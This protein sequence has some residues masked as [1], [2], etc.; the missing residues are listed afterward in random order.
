[1]RPLASPGGPGGTP[2][3]ALAEVERDYPGWQA[4]QAQLAGLVYARRPMTSP[5]MV[6]RSTST[7]GLRKEI[8]AAERERGLR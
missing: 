6:V 2:S 4:W 7:E 5:P 3:Q 1:M 8:E